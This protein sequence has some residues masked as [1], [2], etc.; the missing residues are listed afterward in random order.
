MIVT[1][2]WLKSFVDIKITPE[3][4]SNKL[5]LSG[6]EV[7][8]ITDLSIGLKNVVVG[9]IEQITKHPNADKLVVCKINI[10]TEN[11]QIV[12]A[13]TNVREGQL[14]PVALAGANLCNGL[15]IKD[16]V[17]RGE[18][19]QGML[20]GGDELGLAEADY[21]GAG[22]EGILILVPNSAEPGQTIASAL[23]K[24]DCVLDVSVLS[25]RPD[26]QSVI[27]LAKEIAAI[28]GEK[29]NMPKLSYKTTSIDAPLK[30]EIADKKNCSCYIGRVVR[31]I[32]IGESPKWMQERLKLV[33]LRPL[34]NI[35]DITNYV[36]WEIGQPMHVFDYNKISGAKIVVRAGA[37]ERIKALDGKEYKLDEATL[38]IADKDKPIG[39]AGVMG[40]L[41]DSVMDKTTDIVFESAAFDKASIRKTGRRLGLRSDALARYEKGVEP[42]LC[43]LGMNRALSLISELGIGIIAS[44]SAE[45]GLVEV[46]DREL[47]FPYKL[48]NARLGLAIPEQAAIKILSALG[49]KTTIAGGIMQCVVPALR[50]DLNNADDICEEIIRLYGYE[51]LSETL[52][53]NSRITVGGYDK[54]TATKNKVRELMKATGAYEVLTLPLVS[55]GVVAKLLM[56]KEDAKKPVVISNPLGQDYSQMRTQMAHSLLSIIE[57]NLSRRNSDFAIFEV[58]RIYE[59]NANKLELPLELSTLC[60]ATCKSSENFGSIKQVLELVAQKL[61][62]PFSYKPTKAEYLHPNISADVF[63]GNIRVGH[64]GLVHPIVLKNYN[65]ATQVYLFELYLDIIPEGK[66]RKLKPLP[67]YPSSARDLAVVVDESIAVGEM[68]LLIRSKAGADLESVELFDIYTGGQVGNGKKSVA[69]SLVFR[70]AESTLIDAK[71]NAYMEVVLGALEAKFAAKI[72]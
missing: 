12:T 29:F 14:V 47:K 27:G 26:C 10:G 6:F 44:A 21:R 38:V 31:D 45:A 56:N 1:L 4:L 8:S 18:E 39:I 2:N 46:K 48:I 63:V 28:T 64:V 37:G 60:Y 54:E 59:A 66:Q 68:L 7:E 19:S 15:Q 72:R 61:N 17:I 57:T 51:K 53:E 3:E 11:L 36:L 9:H 35:V 50:A 71:V 52:L 16:S 32:K 40:G 42:A 43:T 69:F 20:C 65:I 62:V 5:A 33:G 49:I 67:K 25:N 13:A 70:N 22:T 34:N 23:G 41:A 24:D 30:V 55:P 58:A